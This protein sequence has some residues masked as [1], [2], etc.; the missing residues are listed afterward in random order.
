[1]SA[2]MEFFIYLLVHYAENKNSTAD[3]VLAQWDAAGITDTI[4]SM[5]QQY[6]SEAIENAFDDIDSML[7]EATAESK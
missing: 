2:E 7:Q 5:Y 1:M 3:K 6:H 4:Y